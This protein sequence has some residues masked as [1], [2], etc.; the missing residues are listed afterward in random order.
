M[1]WLRRKLKAR[2]GEWLAHVHTVP[3]SLTP[4]K[5]L[6]CKASS[7][8]PRIQK[9]S[10]HSNLPAS[11]PLPEWFGNRAEANSLFHCYSY[12]W[13]ICIKHLSLRATNP[14]ANWSQSS[15]LLFCYKWTSKPCLR[16]Q[17]PKEVSDYRISSLQHSSTGGKLRP[18]FR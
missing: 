14:P 7:L 6:L 3:E 2:E 8:I 1:I 9:N 15:G 12:I 18:I 16:H 11:A 13:G 5:E 10:T 17:Q 4:G